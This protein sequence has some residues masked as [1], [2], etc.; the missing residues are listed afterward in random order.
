MQY[1]PLEMSVN[2]NSATE[3]ISNENSN[4]SKVCGNPKF[5]WF[6]EVVL[7]VKELLC[8]LSLIRTFLTQ[9]L[10]VQLWFSLFWDVTRSWLGVGHR[11][12][13]TFLK[14]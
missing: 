12:F 6:K 7:V 5:F 11:H 3:G 14:G 9:D 1:I 8:G 13:G 4:L 10:S 2:S